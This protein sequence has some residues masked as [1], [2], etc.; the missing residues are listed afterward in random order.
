MIT[1]SDPST[2]HLFESTAT[3]TC[4]IGTHLLVGGTPVR[5]CIKSGLG[6]G[7]WDGSA[8]VCEG[9]YSYAYSQI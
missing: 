2:P 4:N 9:T 3:Y 8:P 6:P 5:N 1:Y 7:I